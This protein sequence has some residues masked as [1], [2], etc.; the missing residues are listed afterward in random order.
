LDLLVTGVAREPEV[1]AHL[2]EWGNSS[3]ADAFVGMAVVLK[4]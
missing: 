4:T 1:V 2:L 3:G